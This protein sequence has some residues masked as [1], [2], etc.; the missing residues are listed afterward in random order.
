MGMR[1]VNFKKIATCKNK[2]VR[3]KN[4]VVSVN[5]SC[6]SIVKAIKEII[7]SKYKE[8]TNKLPGHLTG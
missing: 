7:S 3:D 4:K 1:L 8:N 6:L 2:R 5:C